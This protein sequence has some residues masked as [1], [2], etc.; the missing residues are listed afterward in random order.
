MPYI[1]TKDK[2]RATHSPETA[3]ELNFQITQAVQ[4][5]ANRNGLSYQTIN[6]VVGALESVKAEFQRRVVA[7]YEDFKIATNGDVYDKDLLSR[8]DVG[9]TAV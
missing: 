8:P 9:H 1:K 7:P 5:F 6:D 4:D 2:A 3:G